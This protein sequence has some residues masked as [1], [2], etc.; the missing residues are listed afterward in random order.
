MEYYI[1]ISVSPVVLIFDLNFSYVG[2][3]PSDYHLILALFRKKLF[4]LS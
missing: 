4:L 1:K 3:K 2:I